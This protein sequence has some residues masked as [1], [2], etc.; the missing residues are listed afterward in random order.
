MVDDTHASNI[1]ITKILISDG[2]MYNIYAQ[3][4]LEDV[5]TLG[6]P[7]EIEEVSSDNV[8]S[9]RNTSLLSASECEEK[10]SEIRA[11]L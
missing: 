7:V 3:G 11:K 8:Y 5:K 1:K 10:L 4:K 2:K 9:I 6:Y